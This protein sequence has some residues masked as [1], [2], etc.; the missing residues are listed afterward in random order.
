MNLLNNAIKFTTH[1]EV[2]LII[3]AKPDNI[4]RFE[5]KD[6]G[7]GLTK[8]QISKLFHS[9]TQADSGTSRKYG[10]SGLGLSISKQLVK[11]MNGTIWVESIH[12][13]GSNFVCELPLISGNKEKIKTDTEQITKQHIKLLQG[14]K[15]SLS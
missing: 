4:M 2:T 7:I 5:V 10:G 9:F 8:E 1:G 3:S 13:K 6:T 14:S 15:S 11:M 12:G